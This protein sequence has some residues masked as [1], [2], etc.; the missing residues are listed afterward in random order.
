MLSGHMD[1]A[2]VAVDAAYFYATM[3]VPAVKE[4]GPEMK[5]ALREI[6]ASIDESARAWQGRG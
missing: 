4:M 1:W 6:I 3:L 5:T 2:A